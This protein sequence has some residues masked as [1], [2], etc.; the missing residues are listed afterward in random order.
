[1]VRHLSTPPPAAPRSAPAHA[2][3]DLPTPSR[4]P[5][6]GPA[7]LSAT[8]AA[9]H[10]PALTFPPARSPTALPTLRRPTD[11]RL[12]SLVLRSLAPPCAESGPPAGQLRS[13]CHSCP[14]NEL[15][16]VTR[17]PAHEAV[18]A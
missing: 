15:S 3:T 2:V 16:S 12:G 1:M 11:L 9:S 14:S 8:R 4:V 17:S 13:P 5:S 6:H 18:L 10:H 7:D